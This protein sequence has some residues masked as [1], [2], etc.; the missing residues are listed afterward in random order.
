MKTIFS[1]LYIMIVVMV[2]GAPA[3][4]W[5]GDTGTKVEKIRII[6]PGEAERCANDFF[7]D[8]IGK[9]EA[10]LKVVLGNKVYI[11]EILQPGERR[12]FDLPAT[13]HVARLRGREDL[14]FDDVAIIINLGPKAH[15]RV[16]CID[17]RDN[18]LKSKD[19]LTVFK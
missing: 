14:S 12:A 16:R 2:I 8:N 4:V 7:I 17:L 18:P 5:A 6:E 1:F 9:E 10:D 13:I 3:N 15:L 19:A 11:S